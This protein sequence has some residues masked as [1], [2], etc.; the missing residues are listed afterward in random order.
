MLFY[1]IPKNQ[2][3]GTT[4]KYAFVDSNRS[5]MREPAIDLL[6]DKAGKPVGIQ[7][8]IGQRP[9]F[10]MGN[11]RSGGDIE[12]CKFCQS[13]HYPSFQMIVNHDDS[14][15]EYYYQEKDTASLK[16]AAQNKWHVISMKND[17]KNDI[18]SIGLKSTKQTHRIRFTWRCSPAVNEWQGI[19]MLHLA[20]RV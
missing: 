20:S 17:W 3:V 13:N 10:S 11:E 6:C 15:R 9:V 1:G 19:L 8:H 4:F 12:M 5:I 14:T 16:A 7:T 2:V 18:P